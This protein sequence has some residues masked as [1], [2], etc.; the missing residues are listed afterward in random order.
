MNGLW[1]GIGDGYRWAATGREPQRPECSGGGSGLGRFS[2]R[3]PAW[4][5]GEREG[6]GDLRFC[7]KGLM[8]FSFK[9]DKSCGHLCVPDD[10]CLTLVAL[11]AVGSARGGCQVWISRR[12]KTFL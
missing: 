7:V 3:K 5:D 8:G 2:E 6:G 11:Y 4:A 12:F 9:D 1:E 10:V